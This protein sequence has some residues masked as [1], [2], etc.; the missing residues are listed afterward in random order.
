MKVTEEL[1]TT[2]NNTL[3]PIYDRL[4]ITKPYSF[5]YIEE[6]KE[7]VADTPYETEED[8][9]YLVIK[10]LDNNLGKVFLKSPALPYEKNEETVLAGIKME[11]GVLQLI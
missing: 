3:K 5:K 1:N 6:T 7:F 4:G 8:I 2:I 11:N 10:M 9:Y